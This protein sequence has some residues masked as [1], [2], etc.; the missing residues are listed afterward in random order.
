MT[1]NSELSVWFLS[2]WY[3]TRVHAT[4]GNF[5]Q[6]H[7]EAVSQFCKVSVLHVCTDPGMDQHIEY[8]WSEYKGFNELIIYIKPQLKN[9]PLLSGLIRYINFRRAYSKGAK[10]LTERYGSPDIIHANILYPVSVFAWLL[11]K[12][13]HTP[14]VI[15]EHWTGYLPEDPVKP[16]KI[17]LHVSSH[18][19]KAAACIMPV[20][21]H[22]GRAMQACGLKGRYHTITNVVNTELFIPSEIQPKK[23]RKQ[24]LHISTLH[25]PQKNFAG[26]LES[27][28]QLKKHRSDFILNVVSDGDAEPYREMISRLGLKDIVSFKGRM[29]TEQVAAE[30]KDADILVLFSRYEN[31]PCVIA[32]A[33]SCGVPV[34]S[35][36]VGGIS[37]H[38]S[39]NLGTLVD[40]GDQPGFS[41]ALSGMLDHP[42]KYDKNILREYAINHFSN[43]TI[44]KKFLELYHNIISGK[45]V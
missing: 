9:I 17:P 31:F 13:L 11:S 4:R 40:S 12:K 7:I 43:E 2:S 25:E 19:S 34:L 35:T 1:Q 37:E 20:T 21:D 16:G 39:E 44:G 41:S 33:L 45:F 18:L 6:R 30:M 26:L 3:P 42:E 15:S 10:L 32:E 28:A 29:T 36:N 23:E 8:Y 14:F 24:L 27:L 5:V 38:I 22:L